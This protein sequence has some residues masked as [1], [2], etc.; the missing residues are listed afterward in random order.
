[1]RDENGREVQPGEWMAIEAGCTCTVRDGEQVDNDRWQDWLV[2]HCPLH[3]P[4]IV[5]KEDG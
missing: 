1:M 4:R 5:H 2:R 3:D